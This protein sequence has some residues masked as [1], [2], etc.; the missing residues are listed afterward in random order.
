MQQRC[1]KSAKKE[2]K[3]NSRWIKKWSKWSKTPQCLSRDKENYF[4]LLWFTSTLV[5]QT[6]Q[7][8][9]SKPDPPHSY[10]LLSSEVNHSSI[11][12]KL[13]W[14][15]KYTFI[16]IYSHHSRTFPSS[17]RV[18]QS[19]ETIFISKHSECVCGVVCVYLWHG[20]QQTGCDSWFIVIVSH[21]CRRARKERIYHTIKSDECE[22]LQTQL[23]FIMF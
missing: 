4:D 10:T 16:H 13:I 3:R 11:N 22:I 7:V 20:W 19:T 1:G 17:V 8:R 9:R 5:C 2:K 23:M 15:R 14:R 21:R 18:E 6:S 12:K